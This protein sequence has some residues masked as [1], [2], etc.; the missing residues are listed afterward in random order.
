[1]STEEKKK[2]EEYVPHTRISIAHI[3]TCERNCEE[4]SKK[5]E[6]WKMKVDTKYMDNCK[7]SKKT[8]GSGVDLWVNETS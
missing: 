8:T 7:N 4:I 2:N 6:A 3:P 1:M 5:E